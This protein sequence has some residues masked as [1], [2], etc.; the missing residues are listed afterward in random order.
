[1]YKRAR[2][3]TSP[4]PRGPAGRVRAAPPGP[5]G[6]VA[7]PPAATSP[8]LNRITLTE[9]RHTVV[10]RND[11]FPAH[12]LSVNVTAGETTTLRHRFGP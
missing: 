6:E 2:A 3:A 12:T 4:P 11:A 10:L 1:M 7:A 5:G 8:P 9:G